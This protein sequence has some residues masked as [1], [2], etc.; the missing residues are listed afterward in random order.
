MA[1]IVDMR[2]AAWGLPNMKALMAKAK[3]AQ[4]AQ[5]QPTAAWANAHTVTDDNPAVPSTPVILTNQP[6]PSDSPMPKKSSMGLILGAGAA[7][8]AAFYFLK[9]KKGG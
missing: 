7:L 1:E 4:A 3:A 5:V 2:G 6:V 8:A 9:K